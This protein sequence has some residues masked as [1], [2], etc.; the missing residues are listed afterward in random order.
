MTSTR[1]VLTLAALA[2]A[3]LASPAAAQFGLYGPNKVQYRQFEWRTLRGEHVD[4]YFYPEE[5]ELARVALTYAEESY[6][7]L[8]AFFRHS[9]PSRIPFFV[10]A[11]HADFEQTNLLPFVPPEGLLGFTEFARSRVVLP[12]RGSYSEFRHTIR[13][14]LVH[15]FQL[16]KARL[17][18]SLYPRVRRVTFPLWFSE[19]LA[20]YLSGGE[21][22]Q[23]EMILRD[24]AL[25]SRLPSIEQLGFAGG[26]IVY[27]IGGSLVRWLADTYGEWRLVQAYD[28]TWKY[29]DL[30]QLVLA[31]FGRSIEELTEEWH[32]AM[33]LRYYPQ[34]VAQRPLALDADRLAELAIK[35]AVWVPPDDSANPLVVYLSPRSGYT[36][37]YA[38]PLDGGRERT[39]IEGERSS[40]FES[41]HAFDSRIDV[42]AEGIL[43]FAS[44]FMDRDALFLWDVRRG[45]RVGRY[46]F[47]DLVSILS[48]AF[49]P[50][51]RRVVFSGLTFSGY[52]DLYVLDLGSGELTRLTADRFQDV[53]PAFSPDG[54][55]VVF[56]SDRAAMGAE[57]AMNLYVLDVATHAL[58]P[59]TAGSWADRGPRWAP[60]DRIV[61]TSDRRGVQDIY[62][63]DST[64]AGRRETGVPGGTYDPVWVPSAQRYVVGGFE[65]LRFSI[66]ALRPPAEP[67]P[68][69]SVVLDTAAAAVAAAD[70]VALDSTQPGPG[71][72]WGELDEGRYA[73]TEPA[74]F[75]RR[76]NLELAAA[77]AAFIPGVA[78]RQQ[79]VFLLSDLLADNLIYF[80]LAFYQQSGGLKSF[81]SDI[82]GTVVY[83]NQSRRLNWGVGAFR[84]RGRFYEG[85]FD[86]VY[87]ETAAGGF[88]LV[89]YPLSRFTRV[90]AR[91][92]LE[93]SDRVDYTFASSGDFGFPSRRG[94]LASQFLSY[95][96][97]N[98]LWLETG[99]I[100][101]SRVN[102]TGGLVTDL[103]N[104]RFDSWQV[105]TDAR[106]YVRLG[107]QAALALRGFAF[108]SGGERPDRVAIGGSLALR[109]YPRFSY[110]AGN[111]AVLANTEWRF[112]LTDY[113]SFGF[114]FGEWRFPGIQ[115]ALFFDVGRAWF[116]NA[117]ARGWLGSY[118]FGTR[119]SLGYPFVLRLDVGWRWGDL[120]GRY[121]LPL[122]YRRSRF[123]DFW[124]G[125]NY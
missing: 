110:V 46:Q 63:V 2:L 59:L 76:Y 72:R 117:A 118:G 68:S 62:V 64:G 42:S 4:L 122:N 23:D 60:P 92:Q 44:K 88:F 6:R 51:G 22:T 116:S 26:G 73:R 45:R 37:V 48:P 123:V 18:A 47:P 113:L 58:R 20:E 91:W 12:F 1:R 84:V 5:D 108:L 34:V 121:Q 83:L 9:V 85:G 101:G 124:V 17:H 93:H 31:V 112:A 77:D 43:A 79:A 54:T 52:S 115:G 65:N 86:R 98:S 97:D 90:E 25:R 75:D 99:P 102:V 120:Q 69:D 87:D 33:R 21:D 107:H 80:S 57:G 19:G 67:L 94:V 27:A 49:A 74:R 55:R 95:V 111:N 39:L 11:S 106:R 103:Q 104:A 7:E 16:S 70:T 10:Y 15:V 3:C 40:Q 78:G 36:D 61:F 81:F 125:I 50:D 41:F 53:D 38:V 29:D 114:P 35:P 14:E 8:E 89:R 100:D 28:D 82:N 56:A 119:M 13:H 30:G 109:G 32:H 96:R 105:M 24:L 71:W 66:Y